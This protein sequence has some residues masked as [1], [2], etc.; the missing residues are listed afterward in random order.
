LA[1]EVIAK[2]A[3]NFALQQ[4]DCVVSACVHNAVLLKDKIAICN[5]RSS[6]TVHCLSLKACQR[7]TD[8]FDTVTDTDSVKHVSDRW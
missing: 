4:L 5:I 8:M 2:G 1:A 6:N 3:G 7:A